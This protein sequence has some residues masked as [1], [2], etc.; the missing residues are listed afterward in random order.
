MSKTLKVTCSGSFKASDGDIESFD[1][2]VGIIPAL[3]EDKA[4]QMVV[5]RYAIIWI[6]RAKKTVNGAEEPKYKRVMKVRQVFIDS[7]EE[8]DDAP[9]AV[10]SYVGKDIMEMNFE[11]L[12][13]F[14]AANDLSGVPLYKTCSLQH[15]RR[16]AWSEAARK[17]HGMVGPEYM[18][19]NQA[20]K[21]AQHEPITADAI[22]RRAGGHVADIEE[23]ID[24]ANLELQGKGKFTANDPQAN[25]SKLSLDQLKAIADDKKVKY[26]PTI[27]YK[28]LYDKIYGTKKVA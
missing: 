24:R 6:G 15:A 2:I 11:E 5:R 22:V 23:T 25:D 21:P 27:G 3:D 14:A 4:L 17:I 10:L 9:N 20:F 13:D 16:V 1:N 7:I 8:N 28:Q 26:H 12:Q 19:T 18:W